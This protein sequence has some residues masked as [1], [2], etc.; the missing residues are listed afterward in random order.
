M[1]PPSTKLQVEER[2][3]LGNK[4]HVLPVLLQVNV[5]ACSYFLSSFSP[6]NFKLFVCLTRAKLLWS[7]NYL[8][9]FSVLF[10]SLPII[11]SS[12]CEQTAKRF[13][14]C[15]AWQ[16][17]IICLAFTSKG[18]KTSWFIIRANERLSNTLQKE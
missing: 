6:S 13:R 3:E 9:Y 17:D 11:N 7:F 12:C 14:F 8:N 10:V 15:T 4:E 2:K 1:K 5:W 16:W 18:L